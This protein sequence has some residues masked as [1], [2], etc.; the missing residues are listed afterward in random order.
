MFRKE[1]NPWMRTKGLYIIPVAVIALSAFATPELNNRVDAITEKAPSIIASKVTTNS[2]LVQENLQKNEVTLV[3][4]ESLAED[5]DSITLYIVDG[6]VVSQTEFRALDPH[7]IKAITIFKDQESIKK[8]T[9]DKNVSVA[10]VADL[11]SK[12]DD[13]ER[14]SAVENAPQ[15][16]GGPSE[17]MKY[18]ATNVRYPKIAFES[19]ISGRVIVEF[20]VEKDGSLTNIK[21]LRFIDKSPKKDA[22]TKYEE[23][24]IVVISPTKQDSENSAATDYEQ[25]QQATQVLMAEAVRVVASMPNWTPGTHN[26][27]AVRVKYCIPITFRLQ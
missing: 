18:L 21:A 22:T 26:G 1:S 13:V 16:P 23:S 19:G 2:A 12:D 17:M 14:L 9:D 27:M 20:V 4:Q 15:F 24:E 8:Y 10:F 11:D 6:K 7:T 25:A 5:K 3:E